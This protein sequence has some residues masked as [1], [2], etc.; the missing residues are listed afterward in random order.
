VGSLSNLEEMRKQNPSPS[1]IV[2]SLHSPSSGHPGCVKV[3]ESTELPLGR[4][5]GWRFDTISNFRAYFYIS[6]YL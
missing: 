4:K 3:K 1:H 6:R 2:Y 5:E